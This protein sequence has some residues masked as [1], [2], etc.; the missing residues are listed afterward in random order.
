MVAAGGLLVVE[1]RPVVRQVVVRLRLQVV[2]LL[3]LVEAVV[4]AAGFPVVGV[5][6]PRNPYLPRWAAPPLDC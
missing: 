6:A 3:L 5:D 2:R 1:A 4:E